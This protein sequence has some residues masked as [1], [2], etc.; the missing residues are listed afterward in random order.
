MEFSAI[1]T[2][3]ANSESWANAGCCWV[4]PPGCAMLNGV[5]VEKRMVCDG[6]ERYCRQIIRVFIRQSQPTN[7]SYPAAYGVH[8]PSDPSHHILVLA[9]NCRLPYQKPTRD[10]WCHIG[11][12]CSSWRKGQGRRGWVLKVL[13]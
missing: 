12:W 2:T 13:W 1:S 10:P 7:H 8:S 6:D 11:L 3:S 5:V 9:D 4:L